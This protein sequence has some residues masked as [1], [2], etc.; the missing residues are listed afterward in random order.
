MARNL[1]AEI[2]TK[3]S[4]P[5]SIQDEG[6]VILSQLAGLVN[7][8]GSVPE[9]QDLV[10]R[11]LAQREHFGPFTEILDALSKSEGLYPYLDPKTL[12][13][14]DR[15]SYEL[16]RPMNLPEAVFHRKQ[17]HVYN[18]LLEGKNVALS[19][20]T[21]FGKSFIIDAMVASGR[22]RNIAI[23]VPTI[24][25][26][27][28]T[29]RRLFKQFNAEYKIITHTTQKAERRNIYVLT[30]ERAVDFPK[31]ENI[32][33]LVVDE[34]Y[35]LDPEQDTE[36]SLLLN[37]AFYKLCSHRTQFY[38]LGPNIE[39]IS[40]TFCKKF[41]CVFYR[42]DYATVSSEIVRVSAPRPERL[43]ELV[44]LCAK[45]EEPTLIYC[46]SPPSARSV[47]MALL[48]SGAF[49]EVEELSNAAAWIGR[50]YHSDW[51]FAKA[52]RFGIGI[53]HGKIPR[54]LS[55][56]AVRAFNGGLIRIL[57]CTS[58]LIE[59][60]N[61][62]AKNVVVFDN[63]LASKK[64]D[65]FTFSNIVGRSGRM[66]SHFI[67]RV[68]LFDEPPKSELPFVDIP[69]TDQSTV[70]GLDSLLLQLKD[71]D[72]TPGSRAR[73]ARFINQEELSLSVLRANN[74]IDPVAQVNLAKE[75]RRNPY[76]Y[77][78]HL[79]WSYLP[80]WEQ[81]DT[82]CDLIWRF[83]VTKGSL[84]G[85]RSGR[86]LAFLINKFRVDA[87]IPSLLSS[88]F[89]ATAP[90]EAIDRCLDFIRYWPEFNFPRYLMA[91][92]RIQ[93]EVFREVG[94]TPGDYS[95]FAVRVE[96]HFQPAGIVAL[97]EYG[98]PLQVGIKLKRFLGEP[99]DVDQA[100]SALRRLDIDRAPLSEFE[101]L[102][103]RDARAHI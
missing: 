22:F 30:Q 82:A 8:S 78:P 53:H 24:A 31:L 92:S 3:L 100:L 56:F 58:T 17:T 34:F 83:F 33:F 73:V 32:D 91:L 94:R 54:S 70:A 23:V 98:I 80:N 7:E 44:R 16:H 2:K 77:H 21:S 45:L 67:G 13:F 68:Y 101:K 85:V 64:L 36:R 76:K 102:L 57:V 86:H 50:E 84:G 27:D 35:K 60:V 26:I 1:A 25:L 43:P 12:A 18:L 75:I 89:N 65:F 96:N 88:A 81:L 47:A 97:E 14:A 11:A 4:S 9:V 20:P 40:E 63:K 99:A 39:G 74:G 103:V 69:L 29:R 48:E 72:L 42:T 55:N 15:L 90:D 79:K 19:A 37:Q 66:F 46:S 49:S 5:A 61:T 41:N 95:Y 71:D 52:L 38:L 6:F 51:S 87:R 10:L 93:D 28:E 62:K 59:G